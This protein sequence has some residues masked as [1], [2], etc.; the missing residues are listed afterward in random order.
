MIVV[1]KLEAV[2]ILHHVIALE[3]KSCEMINIHESLE[4]A[5]TMFY[6]SLRSNLFY[7][8][9]KQIFLTVDFHRFEYLNTRV[10]CSSVCKMSAVIS[11]TSNGTK[12]QNIKDL[13][14][15][16]NYDVNSCLSEKST[17]KFVLE[18]NRFVLKFQKFTT[19]VDIVT[20][21]GSH[22]TFNAIKCTCINES[23]TNGVFSSGISE[24]SCAQGQDKNRTVARLSLLRDC[25]IS[26]FLM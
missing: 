21:A 16:Y 3:K 8:R 10:L 14:I 7:F 5:T 17:R 22:V 24:I 13:F 20:F 1:L 12:I 25:S 9:A 23:F 15:F 4:C 2:S 26:F 18:P 11:R 6:A 19:I